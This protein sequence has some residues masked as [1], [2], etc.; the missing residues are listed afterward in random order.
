MLKIPG[1]RIGGIGMQPTRETDL[2]EGDLG[3]MVLIVGSLAG[4]ATGYGQCGDIV[5]AVV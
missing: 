4:A 1:S 5:E 3:I 2:F